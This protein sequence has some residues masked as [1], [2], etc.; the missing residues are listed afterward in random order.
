MRWNMLQ[1]SSKQQVYREPSSSPAAPVSANCSPFWDKT[2]SESNRMS[3]V[4]S[5]GTEDQQTPLFWTCLSTIIY[6]QGLG[7]VWNIALSLPLSL[8]PPH[9]SSLVS[10][11]IVFVCQV[12]KV[13]TF[14][15][16]LPILTF[17]ILS[18]NPKIIIGKTTQQLCNF[19]V[20]H[21]F[22][23]CEI[24]DGAHGAGSC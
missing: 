10:M 18:F 24:E 5:R 4:Q 14:E 3:D 1:W 9:V 12:A 7:W 23:C 6:R 2:P 17:S 13:E 20:I 19:C 16:S 21:L 15:N 8:Y 22:Y 11:V